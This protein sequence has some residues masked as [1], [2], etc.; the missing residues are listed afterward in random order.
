MDGEGFL[1]PAVDAAKCIRCGLCAKACPV[2]ARRMPRRPLKVVSAAAKDMGLRLASSS[3]GIFTLLADR[4]IAT[5]GKVYGAAWA[6]GWKVVHRGIEDAAGLA[7]LR[8]SKYMQSDVSGILRSVKADL[9]SGRKVLFSGTPCQI[10]GV[11]GFLGGDR[12]N[13][14]C[15]E[16]VCHGV[17]SPDVWLRF[18]RE[19]TGEMFGRI[20]GVSF[21]DK[22]IEGFQTALRIDYADGTSSVRK[23]NPFGLAFLFEL[24]NRPSCHRCGFRSLSSGADLVLGDFSG[25]A[26]RRPDLVDGRGV[27]LVVACTQRGIDALAEVEGEVD[28]HVFSYED[29]L[30]GN[31]SLERSFPPHDFRPVFMRRFRSEGVASLVERLLR[32]RGVKRRWLRFVSFLMRVGGAV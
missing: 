1:R 29:A 12:P 6:A 19:T 5:G 27:S 32:A 24:C 28:S 30:S 3:G 23:E 14:L 9:D 11:R 18:L 2:L 7:D 20:S 16:M 17:P 25:L 8:G 31:P 22:S 10:A 13:L 21:R 15:V 26:A 4:T